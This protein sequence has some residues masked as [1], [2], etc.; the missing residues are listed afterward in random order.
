MTELPIVIVGAGPQGL[1][2]AAHLVERGIEPVV[3]E[4][5]DA[6]ADAVR[7]WGHVR[8]FSAW[9]E[10]T[11]AAARRLLEPTGWAQPPRG[12]PTGA[13][14]IADYLAPLAAVLGDRIRVRHAVTAVTRLGRDKVV[15][16]G[17]EEQ[18]FVVHV[19]ADGVEQ[20]LLARAVV[21][22]TGT[23]DHPGP[24]GA[25]GVPAIG[26]RAAATRLTHRIPD[27]VEA[28]AG[29]HVV[30]VGSGHSAAHAVLQLDDLARR[31]PATHVTWVL[32]R[33]ATGGAF[34][35][36]AGDELPQRAALG[37]RARAAVDAGR[38]EMVTGFRVAEIV[39]TGAALT[40]VADDGREVRDVAHAFVLTGFRPNLA[41]L[42]ELR[43]DLDPT[44]DAVGGIAA[45]I[46]PNLHSCGSVGATG[47]RELA[48]PEPGFLI[49]GAKSYGRAPTFLALTGYEQVRSVAAHLAGDHVAAASR[50][51]VL[52][53][54]GVCGGA[55]AFDAPADSCCT[56]PTPVRLP[57][58]AAAVD[59]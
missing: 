33:G 31:H 8:L 14:W 21:D 20:R 48:H 2:L 1:A 35:G 39:D 56:T 52:P 41:P 11:D 22:A 57:G 49:V 43:L 44:L 37:E 10:L 38:V 5:G 45:S 53:D 13:D 34:G 24:A 59:A 54:T 16:S 28:L 29:T 15:S 18:P 25:E 40:L 3:L 47:A 58:R 30:V 32:R 17:R 27:D 51:L 4:R 46:D 42:S 50:E 23:W 55:R 12:Y 36:G 9:D 19:D 7:Q 6:A 26:E